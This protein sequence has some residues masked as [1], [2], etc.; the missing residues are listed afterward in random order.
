MSAPEAAAAQVVAWLR[1][2]ERPV[3]CCHVRPDGDALGSALAMGLALRR[4]G[5]QPLVT[6]GDEPMVVPATLSFLPGQDLLVPPAEVP[7]RPDLAIAFDTSSPDRLGLL[8]DPFSRAS[9]NAAVDHHPSY[10]G[11]AQVGVVDV[12]APA[13]A[14]LV[15]DLIDRLGVDLDV[16][17]ATCLY[18]G[19]TTDTGSFRYAST[20]ASTH[21]LAARLLATGIAHDRI[22]RD[23]WDTS[24]FGFLK[25]LAAALERAELEPMAVAGLGLTWTVIPAAERSRH[26]VAMEDIEGVIDVVRKAAEA[27]V[28]VVCKEDAPGEY[29]VSMR[30]KGR[31]DVSVVATALGGGGH[32]FAA[33]YTSY[34]DIGTLVEKLR[35]ELAV[36]AHLDL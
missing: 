22:A 3:L 30:S 14:V 11:F 15:A 32:R 24:S 34:D 21:E 28:A 26:G 20:T 23:L 10:T 12:T 35:T 1:D 8:A 36:T 6:F 27:E 5:H 17:I 18:T 16:E 31:V 13:T 7:A 4:L 25:V 19:L 29:M 33:G 9:C 2:C